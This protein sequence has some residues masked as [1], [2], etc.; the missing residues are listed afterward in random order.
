MERTSAA[1]TAAEKI[2]YSPMRSISEIAAVIDFEIATSTA[3]RERDKLQAACRALLDFC[4]PNG[5]WRG[6]ANMRGL[7]DRVA[8]LTMLVTR[9]TGKAPTSGKLFT[10]AGYDVWQNSD[11]FY[12]MVK[13]G[14]PMPM[15][16]YTY[17][18]AM[19]KQKGL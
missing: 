16:A 19:L 6:Y 5:H 7:L 15:C 14:G 2:L 12:G 9:D 10:V 1:I 17:L 18:H 4:Y 11:G 3:T 8:P 13:A